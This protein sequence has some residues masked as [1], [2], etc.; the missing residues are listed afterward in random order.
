MNI[1]EL[2]KNEFKD[3]YFNFVIYYYKFYVS[4]LMVN[5]VLDIMN[6]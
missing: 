2:K 3:I 4:D 6:E 1:L 5:V